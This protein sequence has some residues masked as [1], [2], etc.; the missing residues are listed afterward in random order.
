MVL[1]RRES[2]AKIKHI[3]L[4]THDPDKVASFYKDVFGMEEVGRSGTTHVYLSDG[5]LN[6]TIRACKKSDD[7]DVGARG[8]DFSGIHHIGFVVDDVID[9]A[10]RME[11]A[12]ATRLT[13]LEAAGKRHQ[14]RGSQGPRNAEVK[15]SGPDGV[16][17][18]ISEFGWVGNSA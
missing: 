10:N 18:D 9:C 14:S 7:P 2:M 17:I 6:L 1:P 4:T 13:P 12:G 5:D 3:A 8:E 11:Q 16:V 15:L